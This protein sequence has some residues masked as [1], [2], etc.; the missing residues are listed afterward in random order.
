[1]INEDKYSKS[2]HAKYLKANIFERTSKLISSYLT[3]FLMYIVY[4]KF[5]GTIASFINKVSGFTTTGQKTADGA[6]IVVLGPPQWN[7]EAPVVG[8]AFMILGVI[9]I[10]VSTIWA[11]YPLWYFLM[12]YREMARGE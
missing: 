7:I 6:E 4:Q 9:I 2:L 10:V 1:M 5:G 8:K 12:T 11:V 3:V